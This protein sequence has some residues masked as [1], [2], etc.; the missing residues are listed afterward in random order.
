MI[1][2]VVA[3]DQPVVRQGLRSFFDG[4]SA[5]TIVGDTGSGPELIDLLQEFQPDVLIIDLALPG[6]DVLEVTREVTQRWVDIHVIILTMS[7]GE[8]QVQKA[9]TNGAAGYVLRNSTAAELR[10][11]I[12]EVVAGRRYL[13]APLVD[14]AIESIVR[15]GKQPPFD[16]YN[17]LTHREQEVLKLAAGGLNNSAIASRLLISPRTVE[18]HR[19]RLM[20]KLGL[21]TQTELVRYDLRRG[22]VPMD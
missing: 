7:S 5:I 14:Q 8:A 15:A 9:L 4:D 19:A 2:V 6:I 1:R 12:H 21:H 16:A 11:A 10:R 17:T 20:R 13:S 22:I 3:D 18:S